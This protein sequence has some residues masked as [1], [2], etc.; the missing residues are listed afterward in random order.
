LSEAAMLAAWVAR[1]RDDQGTARRHY[2]EAVHYA[3]RA[4]HPLWTAFLFVSRG[5]FAVVKGEPRTGLELYQKAHRELEQTVAPD[6]AYAWLATFCADAHAEMGDRAAAHAELR[7]A[8]SRV[9]GEPQWPWVVG[10]DHDLAHWQ[11]STLAKLNDL[12]AARVTF[13]AASHGLAP[14]ALA[15]AKAEQA[16]LLA[17]TGHIDEAHVLAMEAFSTA[18]Q[19]GI[20]RIV[21]KVRALP[22]HLS[23][24]D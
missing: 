21:R 8:E 22:L 7:N 10:F 13:A 24:I 4:R 16:C 23:G 12:T 2:A 1:E 15:E 11:A 19:Y 14:R 6:P 17:R 20:E 9:G 18:R 5:H 3:E